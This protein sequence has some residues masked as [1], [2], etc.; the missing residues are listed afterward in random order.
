MALVTG[1]NLLVPLVGLASA[2]ILAH[3]LGVD[4]RGESSAALGP[5]LLIVTG[6]TFGLPAALTYVLARRPALTRRALG[7]ASLFSVVLG[8]VLLL[9]A[10]VFR[11]VLAQGDPLLAD[12]IVLGT[13]FAIP[14]LLVGLLRGAAY[15]RQM[16]GAIAIERV[17]NSFLRLGVLAGL[18]A[19]GRLDVTTAVVVMSLT[20]VVAGVAYVGVLRRP[21]V[22]PG[23]PPRDAVARDLVRFGA[24]EWI[25]SVAVML[26][27]R[28]SQ[29]LVTPLSDVAQ[30]GL[31][32]A[33]ITVSDVPYIV[34]Q[35]IREVVF[36]VNSAESD[37]ERLLATSRVV[38]S[39][40][41]A[42]SLVLAVTLP[43]W[44]TVFFGAGFGDALVPTWVLLLSSCIAVPGLIAGAGLDSAGKPARRSIAM[45]LALVLN[46]AGLVAL[47]PVLGATGAAIASLI[48][49][50]FATV[51]MTRADARFRGVRVRRYVVIE[52]QDR[53]T[54]RALV[55]RIRSVSS[56]RDGGS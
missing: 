55:V 35:A 2:P 47:T 49:T 14:A 17:L 20:P 54:V 4:G 40:S 5:N 41:V 19:T 7:W 16:W 56:T 21:S 45:G 42:G 8:A 11:F 23:E 28:M 26:I 18:A 31:L 46:V 53:D 6:A 9:C 3:S 12:L 33:A 29:L 38:T 37:T 36:G 50:V 10:T 39:V 22:K 13:W 44:I 48:S 15:G 34:T 43:W 25:G 27:A 32:V 30:L 24:Q 51:A 52:A 1:A